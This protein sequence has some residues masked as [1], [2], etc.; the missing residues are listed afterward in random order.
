M[1][2]LAEPQARGG[3]TAVGLA[4]PAGRSSGA[5]NSS[6]STLNHRPGNLELDG[7]RPSRNRIQPGRQAVR[8]WPLIVLAAPATV[9]VWS[10]WVR[11]GQMTG[12]GL[13][14]P[15]PGL[16]DS[17]QVNTA[18]TLPVGVE[19]Y[20][21]FA[22]R[23]WLA[24]GLQTSNRTRRF[25]KWPAIGSLLLGMSGQVAYHLLSEARV[26]KAPWEITMAVACLP[27][28]V[29]GMGAALSHLIHADADGG[30]ADNLSSKAICVGSLMP[31]RGGDPGRLLPTPEQ[32]GDLV[33]PDARH[34]G[35]DN[36]GDA[37]VTERLEI[38]R[39]TALQLTSTGTRVSRRTMRDA[40]L[41][42]SNAELGALV[43]AV[44]AEL[45]HGDGVA[46]CP[47]IADRSVVPVCRQPEAAHTTH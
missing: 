12:F 19:A 3:R 24:A 25:A 32:A 37:E 30:S 2:E 16:W 17:F 6:G 8:S 34:D 46:N 5:D 21:A 20:G 40:G 9:A 35:G 45:A 41:R 44:T 29:L 26:V 47:S 33:P 42:G 31:G 15:F 13:V 39:L 4:R 28:L 43:K 11:L 23:A 36:D 10:C 7:R 27:V 22:L 1:T 18:I 38:A 14:R